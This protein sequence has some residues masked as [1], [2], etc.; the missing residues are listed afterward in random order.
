MLE[1]RPWLSWVLVWETHK[2]T[3][4]LGRPKASSSGVSSDWTEVRC[5]L[6]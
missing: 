4:A 3:T 6:W 1:E 5:D 2:I